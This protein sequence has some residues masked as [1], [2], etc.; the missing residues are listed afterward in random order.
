[1]TAAAVLVVFSI[2][3]AARS[4]E[5]LEVFSFSDLDLESDIDP[6]RYDLKK[7]LLIRAEEVPSL[8][9]NV[10]NIYVCSFFNHCSFFYL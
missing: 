9:F 3:C 1:M 7:L 2:K 5:D 10:G 6:L 4:I 8:P